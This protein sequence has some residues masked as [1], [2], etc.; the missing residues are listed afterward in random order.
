MLVAHLWMGGNSTV[1][2]G[3]RGLIKGSPT[4][5][6]GMAEP[7]GFLIVHAVLGSEGLQCPG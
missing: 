5:V 6:P 3:V 1:L 7:W 4:T 2:R